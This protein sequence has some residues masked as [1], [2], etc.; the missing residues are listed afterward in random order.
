MKQ[1]NRKWKLEKLFKITEHIS[2]SYNNKSQKVEYVI[3]ENLDG[4]KPIK[5]ATVRLDAARLITFAPE[6]LDVLKE[7]VKSEATH[8]VA[9]YQEMKEAVLN[10]EYKKSLNVLFMAIDVIAKVEGEI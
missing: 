6:L 2:P 4:T 3:T 9:Y 7:Y 8:D 10:N 5:I 1:A